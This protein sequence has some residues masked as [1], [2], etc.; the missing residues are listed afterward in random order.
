MEISR[1]TVSTT[2]PVAQILGLT[3]IGNEE[4][5]FMRRGYYSSIYSTF[6]KSI[7]SDNLATCPTNN[8]TW[9]PFATLSLCSA[10]T[11]I[12]SFLATNPTTGN[13]PG[14]SGQNASIP[15][16]PSLDSS[17]D[18]FIIGV[19]EP[20]TRIPSNNATI[21]TFAAL[22]ASESGLVEA[23]E[24]SLSLCVQLVETSLSGNVYTE[25]ILQQSTESRTQREVPAANATFVKNYDSELKFTIPDFARGTAFTNEIVVDLFQFKCL[26]GLLEFDTREYLPL[27]QMGLAKMMKVVENMSIAVGRGL[28]SVCVD[29]TKVLGSSWEDVVLVRINWWWFTLPVVVEALA[30]GFFIWLSI[31]NRMARIQLWKSSLVAVLYHGLDLQ[32]LRRGDCP[33]GLYDMEQVAEKMKVSLAVTGSNEKSSSRLM[34]C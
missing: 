24:C 34:R 33:E 21:H 5:A 7:L 13:L 6:N 31:Y 9:A 11:N 3:D 19:T 16:G 1:R 23:I 22:Q 20:S 25:T 4:A 10:C 18:T 29:S 2:F 8:C 32:Q 27:A 17:F 12:T 28:R 26:S 14:K 30:I 15:N